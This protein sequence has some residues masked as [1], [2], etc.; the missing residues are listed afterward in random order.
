M[1][2]RRSLLVAVAGLSMCF[3][4]GS[5]AR[6]QD[7]GPAKVAVVNPARCFAE[8]QE[9]KDLKQKLENDQKQL[10]AEVESRQGKV[11][12]LQAQRDLLKS[13]SPQYAQADQAFMQAAIE[14]DTW[15]KITQAQLQGQQ[16]QQMKTLFD[17]IVQSTQAVAQ[18]RGI[19][20]VIADQRPDLP[21]NLAAINVEQ[22]RG[23]LNSRNIM[24][25]TQRVD[26]SQD[27]IAD[28]DAKYRAGGGA[29][30]SSA[31]AGGG[32]AGAPAPAGGAP[33]PAPAG[34]R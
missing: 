12:D 9:T 10:K 26:L 14:F 15:S 17:K 22:L 1:T 2:M 23:I 11:K 6:A 21:E 27:V 3:A 29:G 20:L 25:A 4:G 13:D 30:S 28:L 32:A 7:A 24:F 19:D 16:K 31:P 18:Q 34:K 33:A 5:I 8:M